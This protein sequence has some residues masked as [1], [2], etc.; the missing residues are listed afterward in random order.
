M[1]VAERQAS[2]INIR[3]VSWN[4]LNVRKDVPKV[5]DRGEPELRVNSPAGLGPFM[6]GPA[7]SGR[8]SRRAAL[9]ATS[10]W[11]MTASH[12]LGWLH[13][14]HES[15]RG[16]DRAAR[17]RHLHVHGQGRECAGRRREGGDHR[18][19]RRRCAAVRTGRCGPDD[20]DRVGSRHARGWQHA[21]G[22]SR[23]RLERE[24]G[25]GSVDP[26]RHRPRQAPDDGR[27]LRSGAAGLVDLAL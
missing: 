21:Q 16:Q 3:K 26:R 27:G 10:C 22:E 17:S 11:A 23:R 13:G 24:A 5:L 14:A 15:G 19:Q 6:F 7:R 4:G 1:T 12:R 18:R 25:A 8:R 20:H 2:A 9:A